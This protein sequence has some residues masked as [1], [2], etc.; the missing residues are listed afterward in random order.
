MPTRQ[1]RVEQAAQ[2]RQALIDAAR[3]LFAERGYFHTRAE[4]IVAAADVGTRG[5][6]YH[7]FADKEALFLAV[8]H[9][10]QA[11]LG[12]AV[13]QRSGGADPLEQLGSTMGAFLD[14]ASERGDVQQILLID[15]PAVLGW[16]TWRSVEAEYGLDA[17]EKMLG[18][19]VD[20]NVIEEQPLRPLA[21]MI[22]ALLDEAAL[23][24]GNAPDPTAAR[25]ELARSIDRLLG[26]LRTHAD[27]HRQPE[28]TA[29][30]N[31]RP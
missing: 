21:H 13:A 3:R 11:S 18:A 25:A 8:L 16:E 20:A 17:I 14:I 12:A 24:I 6:L 15:G 2:T 30:D 9:E 26:G 31:G 19:A 22:L 10:V 27:P 7:H 23:Y 4:D 5:A 29:R 28:P 1:R